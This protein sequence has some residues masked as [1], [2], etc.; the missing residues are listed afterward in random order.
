[1][2]L[3]FCSDALNF[4]FYVETWPFYWRYCSS[5]C[6][7]CVIYFPPFPLASGNG[8]ESFSIGSHVECYLASADPQLENKNNF[9]LKLHW[10]YPSSNARFWSCMLMYHVFLDVEDI[11]PRSMSLSFEDNT[12]GS[13]PW[14]LV[15][16]MLLQS[17]SSFISCALYL[18]LD[19][20]FHCSL[21]FCHI[22]PPFKMLPL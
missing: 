8:Y 12:L 17:A 19:I 7:L 21:V 15:A 22:F 16:C 2:R 1:M 6:H 4:S 9:L 13:F 18:L 3:G 11:I 20:I 5:L 10:R 14:L